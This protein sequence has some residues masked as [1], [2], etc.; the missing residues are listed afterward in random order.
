[1]NNENL[2]P[3]PFCGGEAEFVHSGVEQRVDCKKMVKP[4][5]WEQEC[6]DGDYIARVGKVLFRISY[7]DDEE[8]YIVFC[9][10]TLI[11]G[12]FAS[13]AKAKQSA[14]EFLV[15]LVTAALGVELWG[16]Q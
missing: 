6:E 5:E 1:M 15:D 2:K 4:L 10:T 11:Q 14:Q 12:G 8:K 9:D 13:L 16:K 3:C 7:W